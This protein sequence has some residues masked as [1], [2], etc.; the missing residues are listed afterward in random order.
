M[1]Y[2]GK[3]IYRHL[4]NTVYRFY[5]ILI[6]SSI[7]KFYIYFDMFFIYFFFFTFSVSHVRLSAVSLQSGHVTFFVIAGQ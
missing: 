5:H 3:I 7:Y 2:T 6:E 4:K 1:Y